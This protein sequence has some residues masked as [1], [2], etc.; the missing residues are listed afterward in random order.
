MS[1]MKPATQDS[2]QT[3]ESLLYRSALYGALSLAFHPP[4][5]DSFKVLTSNATQT[6]ILRAASFLDAEQAEHP[7]NEPESLLE[8]RAVNLIQRTEKWVSTFYPL[9]LDSLLTSHGR[10]FGHT[11]RGTVTPYETEYGQEGLFQQPQQ[12]ANLNGFYRAFGLRVRQDE[13]ERPDHIA[14]QLEFMEFLSRK[15]TYALEHG[16]DSMFQASSRAGLLFLKEHL[17]RFGRAFGYGVK[18][19]DPEGFLGM[20]GDFLFDFLTLECVRLQ[21]EAGPS[22]LP[23]R[24]PAEDNVPMACAGEPDLVQIET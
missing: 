5:A 9:D 22:R 3:R 11:V 21:I 14:C 8:S 23:L 10:L 15:Q 6:S 20:A 16:D 1:N 19:Q 2:N 13:R 7:W 12:L 17:G 4:T 18:K 24:S